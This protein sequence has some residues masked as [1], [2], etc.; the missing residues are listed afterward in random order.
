MDLL[1]ILEQLNF[2]NIEQ[3]IKDMIANVIKWNSEEQLNEGEYIR[4]VFDVQKHDVIAYRMVMY[5]VK[6]KDYIMMPRCV[7][8]NHLA[9]LNKLFPNDVDVKKVESFV[10]KLMPMIHA[11]NQLV[12]LKNISIDADGSMIEEKKVQALFDLKPGD[13]S[14]SQITT[15]IIKT[16]N[17]INLC[18][19]VSRNLKK[20]ELSSI[21][22]L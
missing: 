14:A 22:K 21:I 6:D 20:W 13:V 9:E 1:M 17:G 15:G 4:I 2:E 5:D 7:S 8:K 16:P 11:A 12:D 10:R 18:A 19:V 3:L